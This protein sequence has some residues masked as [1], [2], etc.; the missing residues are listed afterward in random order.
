[1]HLRLPRAESQ[2]ERRLIKEPDISIF[3]AALSA[4]L[5]W[6]CPTSAHH[7]GWRGSTR[8]TLSSLIPDQRPPAHSRR[9]QTNSIGDAEGRRRKV[10][11]LAFQQSL[12]DSKNNNDPVRTCLTHTH[13]KPHKQAVYAALP[14]AREGVLHSGLQPESVRE[15]VFGEEKETYFYWASLSLSLVSSNKERGKFKGKRRVGPWRWRLTLPRRW[16]TK[17]VRAPSSSSSLL[18]FKPT[19][20]L[21]TLRFEADCKLHVLIS[22]VTVAY[23]YFNHAH[24]FHPPLP[25]LSLCCCLWLPAA[26]C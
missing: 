10:T 19:W 17:S 14:C 3:A 15:T 26:I 23:A 16:R 2:A 11:A 24:V 6:A 22:L 4:T 7:C 18:T 21:F 12:D 8:R 20:A 1:M 5:P 13:N 9:W 25:A